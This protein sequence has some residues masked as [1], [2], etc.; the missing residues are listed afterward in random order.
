MP[1]LETFEI[2]L[3]RAEF[4]CAVG[5]RPHL[6]IRFEPIEENILLPLPN[7]NAEILCDNLA[8]GRMI[9][10]STNHDVKNSKVYLDF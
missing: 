9:T 6:V 7:L 4:T 5:F 8:A 10:Y 3:I 2:R 1:S